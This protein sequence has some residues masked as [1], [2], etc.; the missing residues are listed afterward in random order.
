MAKAIKFF[1]LISCLIT[2]A[3]SIIYNQTQ[4]GVMLAVTLTFGT[5]AYHFV[6]RLLVGQIINAIFK[7]QI[8]YS[9]KWFF[10][11][12][13]EQNFYKL[14][15][16]KSWKAKMPTY[17]PETF[18]PSKKS[19]E[20]IIMATCQAEIVHEIIVILS[21]VPIIFSIWFGE[22]AVFII[23]SILSALIDLAFVIMQRYNR[24]RILKII[25]S[26]QNKAI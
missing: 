2:V 6:M 11:S 26:K 17:N 19:W 7:N 18:D 3:C 4:S 16:V 10:V 22:L 14:I 1:V 15:N 13:R 5:I 21:F 12:Q 9:R 25:K 23:T 24:P 8:K 20:Q